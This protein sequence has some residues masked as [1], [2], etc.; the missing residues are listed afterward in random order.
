MFLW[1]SLLEVDHF[2]LSAFKAMMAREWKILTLSVPSF[3]V[4]IKDEIGKNMNSVQQQREQ[5]H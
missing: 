5:H 2:K 1:N 3:S 4:Q